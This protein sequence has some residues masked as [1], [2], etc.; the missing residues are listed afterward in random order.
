M[1]QSRFADLTALADQHRTDKGSLDG[2]RHLYTEI[3]AAT[4]EAIRLQE[5]C[6]LELGLLRFPSRAEELSPPGERRVDR[7]P[8]I[9]MWL[10]FFPKATC[11]GFD[12][13]DF[14]AFE[15]P[16]FKFIRGD[17]SVDADIERL[18]R[19]IPSP[20]II[21]DDASHASF[22][23]QRA[24][25][26]LFPIL[27][28][29]GFYAIEDL[30]YSPPFES[31]LPGCRP[32]WKILEELLDTGNLTLDF[33]SA[34]EAQS[35]AAQIG[36][37]FV[38]CSQRGSSRWGPK[39]AIFQKRA[40]PAAGRAV[41][42]VA[43][44]LPTLDHAW[45]TSRMFAFRGAQNKQPYTSAM[46]FEPNGRIS[47]Y[48]NRNETSWRLTDGKLS[49][50]RED[51]APSC[52]A[53]AT[54]NHDGTI[55]FVGKFLLGGND[56]FHRFDEHPVDD[57]P[58]MVVSFDLFDTLVARR[59]YDPI[60]IFHSVERKSGIAGFARLR[61]DEEH[62]LWQAG[63]YGLD[64]IYAVLEAATGWPEA[65]LSRLRMLELAEEWDNL[66]PIREMTARVRPGDLVISD[67]YL[68][69]SFL[70]RVLEEKCGLHEC[71]VHLSSHGKH[72]G[73]IWPQIRSTHRIM[74]HYGDNHHSDVQTARRAKVNAEHVTLARWGRGEQ[75]LVDAG[76]AEFAR[77]VREV[78]LTSFE[79]DP[80]VRSAQLAQYEVN[81][82][83]LIVAS[84]YLLHQARE[85]DVD[86]LL[87]CSRDC[88]LWL[89]LMRWMS[90]RSAAAPVVRYLITSRVLLLSDSSDYRAY[91]SQ[92][93]GARNILVDVSGTGRS[94]SYFLG[95]L[96]EQCATSVFLVAGT[97]LVGNFVNELAPVRNEIEIDVLSH[98]PHEKRLA[99][100]SLNMSLEGRAHEVVFSGRGFE[101]QYQP[102]EFGR[103]S[104]T[105]ITALRAAFMEVMG[106]LE[107]SDL[108][109]MPED[110]PVATLRSAADALI[111]LAGDYRLAYAA[112]LKDINQEESNI[113][114]I[115]LAARKRSLETAKD[116]AA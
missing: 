53:A 16:R 98:Q 43:A 115:A 72:R 44:E 50:L 116:P 26:R 30:H 61:Q 56:I 71:I 85:R 94:P 68:P 70:R 19:T 29:G 52:I 35:I 88:N 114:R 8:S 3:Y 66:I 96:D 14:A 21:I 25:L 100:E 112:M 15:Q 75:I 81:I 104:R 64:D 33:A 31:S 55:S 40:V 69:L 58:P 91:F 62:K 101:A 32:M 82:P 13:A 7:I 109:K 24:F 83:L 89:P 41:A 48:R 108:R 20:R 110:I 10:Q 2:D 73:E 113:A 92:L 45:L 90:A 111:D 47:G 59:C 36:H 93:R 103:V 95:N 57:G 99:I 78:R 17:L 27:E 77:I 80:V 22:H 38:H 107:Q 6:L 97:G 76:L 86:T 11:Y 49:I 105:S 65:V 34:E 9:E 4:F 87:M 84:L 106:R 79:G 63:D 102:N 5:F 28:P 46:R 39:L 23:Q 12:A 37:S 60:S 74:L 18:A 1:T 67:M 42:A 54:R 51:G